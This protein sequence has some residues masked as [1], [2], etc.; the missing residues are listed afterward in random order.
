MTSTKKSYSAKIKFQ[1]V[2]ELLKGEKTA[3]EVART[4]GA[5]PT[6]VSGWKREFLAKGPEVFSQANVLREYEKKIEELE[7]IIG[8]QTIEIALLK[9]FLGAWDSI[10]KTK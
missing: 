10:A 2:M 3:T 9:K 8:K 6:S 4:W 7:N 5:H 1:A